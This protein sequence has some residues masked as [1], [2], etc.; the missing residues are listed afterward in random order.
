MNKHVR[1]LLLLVLLLLI[2]F[3]MLYIGI[4][5][6]KYTAEAESEGVA[7][8]AT[9]SFEADNASVSMNINFEDTYD[10]STLVANK[11]APG[12]SGSFAIA[13]VNTNSDVGVDFELE[14]GT[15]TNIPTN[16]VFYK[17]SSYSEELDLANDTITGQLAAK[18]SVGVTINIYWKW[19]YETQDGD[20][21]DTADGIAAADL[22]IPV[23]ITG[24][25]VAPSE[26][27]ITSHVD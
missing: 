4:T 5:Y 14:F 3:S 6:S 20:D 8:V 12:T 24:V 10:A 25:Q 27:P 22:S 1:S 11:I 18:D 21:D 23:T 16:L 2:S 15:A 19:E 9:W 17:D 26:N 7:T 13:L